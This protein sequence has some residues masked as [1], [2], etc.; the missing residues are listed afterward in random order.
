MGAA[1]GQVPE[2]IEMVTRWCKQFTTLP[3]IVKLTPNVA[4]IKPPALA[5]HRGGADAVSLINTI[6]SVMGVD[7]DTLLIHPH[8]GSSGSHGGYCGPAVKPI[9][10]N[11]VA[12]IARSSAMHELPISGIGG[13]GTWRD[14]AEFIALAAREQASHTFLVP[15]MLAM[16]LEEPTIGEAKFALRKIAYGASPISPAVLA[17]GEA[18][19]GRIFAQTYG[20][21]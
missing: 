18:R 10:L 15:T 9:A 14:A 7:L 16:I 4:D 2:Y 5:A 17:R 3:V 12:E 1:V 11:M 19:F 21:A 20:Q 13:I 6:N 8:T